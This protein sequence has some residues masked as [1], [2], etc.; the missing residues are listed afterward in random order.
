M[1][2]FSY[3]CLGIT[4]NAIDRLLCY[5]ATK[6]L[7]HETLFFLLLQAICQVEMNAKIK[8]VGIVGKYYSQYSKMP[9]F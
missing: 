6:N 1:I 8:L 3:F 5:F 9:D 4:N 2:F 7:S